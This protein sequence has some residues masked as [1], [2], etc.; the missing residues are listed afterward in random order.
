MLINQKFNTLTLKEYIFFIDNYKKYTDFNTLGLYRSI[1]ENEKLNLEGKIEVRN[2]A[3]K[4][5]GK[6]FE[7]L[8]LKDPSTYF[9][10]STLGQ[11]IT[12]GGEQKIWEDIRTNQ[13]KILEDKQIKHRN[14]GNYSKHNCGYEDC[15]YNGLMIKQ[16]SSL[17]EENMHFNSDKTWNSGKIKSDRSKK[18]RKNEQQII[19]KTIET[20]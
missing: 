12:K 18:D 8:Q 19:K 7:F 11:E 15:P 5:F 2:Y 17:A 3:H 6:T 9:E 10:V 14:F 20:K 16:N 13:Q 4:I 1:L